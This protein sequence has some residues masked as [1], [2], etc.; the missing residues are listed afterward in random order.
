MLQ[1][2]TGQL[3]HPQVQQLIS[4][5]LAAMHA[6][7]PAESVHALALSELS[8][9]DI[10]LYSA[11][12]RQRL[13]GIA[14]IKKWDTHHYELKS[15]RTASAFLRQGVASDLLG[16]IVAEVASMGGLSISLETGSSEQFEAAH[17]LYEQFAFVDCQ[18]FADYQPDT[19][20]RYM[21]RSLTVA[22]A[23]SF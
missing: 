3:S 12:H 22:R 23:S 21:T 9:S 14:A 7:T 11:W 16:Y 17:K 1:I 20:S 5:H 6:Q 18:P 4:V 19:L 13:A 2:K 15:M 10:T 8:A